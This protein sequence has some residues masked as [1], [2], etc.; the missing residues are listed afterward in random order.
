MANHMIFVDDRWIAL[1][2]EVIRYARAPRAV[3]IAFRSRP[4]AQPT[5]VIAPA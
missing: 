5:V 4:L 1:H 3:V 2:Q